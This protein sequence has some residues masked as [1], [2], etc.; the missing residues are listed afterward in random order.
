M[1]RLTVSQIEQLS[2]TIAETL[3]AVQ[4]GELDAS[5]AMRQFPKASKGMILTDSLPYPVGNV[6][7]QFPGLK[8]FFADMKNS[9]DPLLKPDKLKPSIIN[10]WASVLAFT[11]LLAGTTGTITK[12]TVL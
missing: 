3:H 1:P 6:E 9:H 7:K 11:K 8:T 2:G 12:E 4:R 5:T 10:S